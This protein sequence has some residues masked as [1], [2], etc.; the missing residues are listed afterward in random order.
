M[1]KGQVVGI[2]IGTSRCRAVLYD[3]TG[4][5]VAESTRSYPILNPKPG[6]Q[7]QDPEAVLKAFLA[8]LG[9]TIGRA[10]RDSVLG[11]GLSCYFHSFMAVD[12]KDRPLTKCIIWTDTRSRNAARRIA[13]ESDPH[14]LYRRTGCP[15]HPMYP[16][17]KAR[18]LKQEVPSVFHQ[19]HKT[20]SLKEYIVHEVFGEYVVDWSVAS[21]SG[22]FNIHTMQWD[23]EAIELAGLQPD[24]LSAVTSPLTR[25]PPIRSKYA[26]MLQLAESIPIIIGGADGTLSSLGVGAV[27]FREAD[28][29]AATGAA[30]RVLVPEPRLDE[31]ARTWCYVAAPNRWAV[32]GVT[33]AGLIYEWFIR[34]FETAERQEAERRGMSLYQLLDEYVRS[35]PL[36]S[37]G[38]VFLPFIV[39]ARTPTWNPD[40]RGVLFGLSYHHTSKHILRALMEGVDY[41]RFSALKAVE[42][43]VGGIDSIRVSGGFVNSRSWLQITADVYGRELLVPAVPQNT[44]WGAAFMAMLALG[45]VERLEDVKPM[46]TIREVVRPDPGA[47]DRYQKLFAKY[48]RLCQK[49]EDEFGQETDT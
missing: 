45:L 11:I 6:W 22:I 21:G 43:V 24:H 10:S 34:E 3:T 39:G 41:N 23:D 27:G 38:L 9:E 26:D 17:C 18:W 29:M 47:H 33:A 2:D 37:D 40:A 44:A 8:C 28:S 49:L 25:L 5:M 32:G 14:A 31:R 16:I 46:V 20:V 19:A 48:E 12:H 7:E 1:S 36:G 30:V 13:K 15:L 35:V 4:R 42:E